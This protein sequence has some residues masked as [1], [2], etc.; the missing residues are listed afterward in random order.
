MK[1][2][3]VTFILVALILGAVV[4]GLLG[5]IVAGFLPEDSEVAKVFGK[6]IEIGVKTIQVDFYA[7]AFTF[8]LMLKVNFM[9]VLVLLLVIIYFRWWYL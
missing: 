7:I 8:G 6:S 9:S 1:K 4:G 3:E 2:R 5:D